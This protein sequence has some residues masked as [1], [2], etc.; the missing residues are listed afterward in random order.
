MVSCQTIYSLFSNPMNLM[1]LENIIAKFELI[2][3]EVNDLYGFLTQHIRRRPAMYLGAKSITRLGVFVDGYNTCVQFHS[4]KENCKPSLWL[5][6]IWV[7]KKFQDRSKN[8]PGIILDYYDGNEELALDKFFELFDEFRKISPT[9][10]VKA[11]VTEAAARFF[12]EVGSKLSISYNSDG[13]PI[14][15]EPAKSIAII[16]YSHDFG[17]TIGTWD[18]YANFEEAYKRATSEYGDS[19]NWEEIENQFLGITYKNLV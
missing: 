15:K 12:K 11:E 6:Y 17:S 1:G 3:N 4:I 7:S 10:I 2:M 18:Y 13:N 16:E 19:L 5:F 8:W 9:R 14:E